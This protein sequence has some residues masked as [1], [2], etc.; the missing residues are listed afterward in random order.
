MCNTSLNVSLER[1]LTQPTPIPSVLAASHMFWEYHYMLYNNWEGENTGW[2]T[3]D[4]LMKFA[5]NVGLDT[6]EFSKCMSDNKWIELINASGQDARILGITGTP[7]FFLIGP[8]NEI[9]KIH[10]AQPYSTFKQTFDLH[11]KK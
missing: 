5:Q 2:I 10:G 7:S 6:D 4:I 9:V 3:N 1:M 11:L 8:E